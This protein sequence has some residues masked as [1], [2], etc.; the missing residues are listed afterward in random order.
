MSTVNIPQDAPRTDSPDEPVP[1]AAEETA[2]SAAEGTAP[3]ADAAPG[4]DAAAES[5]PG[6]D[7]AAGSAPATDG[8]P[9][10]EAAGAAPTGV[11]DVAVYVRRGR[12]PTLGF[13]VAIAIALP[14]L[15]GLVIAP[16]LGIG[17]LNGILNFMLVAGVFVGLPLAAIVCFV[18]AMRQRSRRPRAPRDA[19]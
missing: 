11:G 2:P 6:T 12:T 19:A 10:E 15:A 16:L 9:A 8:A 4:T 13:W 3:S 14:V 17:T 7:A 18:D 5:A 1:S